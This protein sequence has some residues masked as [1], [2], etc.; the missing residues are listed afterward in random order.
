MLHIMYGLEMH[1][2]GSLDLVRAV[3]YMTLGFQQE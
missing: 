2:I 3:A 1:M